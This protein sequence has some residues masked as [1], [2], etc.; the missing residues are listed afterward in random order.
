MEQTGYQKNTKSHKLHGFVTVAKWNTTADVPAQAISCSM[1][2]E[3]KIECNRKESSCCAG[4]RFG[5]ERE[6]ISL[7]AVMK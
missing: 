4:N 6:D 7:Q 2:Y 3:S 1:E 5:F